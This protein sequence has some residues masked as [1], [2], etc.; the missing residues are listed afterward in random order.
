MGIIAAAHNPAD[1][2]LQYMPMGH[3]CLVPPTFLRKADSRCLPLLDQNGAA[4]VLRLQSNPT[5][6][7]SLKPALA[8]G[9][10]IDAP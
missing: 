5:P 1:C 3:V 2:R 8:A 6:P 9:N 7:A 10:L 4:R